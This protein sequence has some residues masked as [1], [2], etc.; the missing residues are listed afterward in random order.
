MDIKLFP[1]GN[2]VSIKFERDDRVVIGR[3]ANAAITGCS[4]ENMPEMPEVEKKA[5]NGR[6]MAI[7]AVTKR[8]MDNTP[9]VNFKPVPEG[10]QVTVEEEGYGAFDHTEVGTIADVLQRYS[11]TTVTEAP[12]FTSQAGLSTPAWQRAYDG[13]AAGLMADQLNA[14]RNHLADPS[15]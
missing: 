6:M 2:I 11:D 1:E 7:G 8:I 13:L 10:I 4:P 15:G 3:A 9:P 5:L 14:Q 12:R